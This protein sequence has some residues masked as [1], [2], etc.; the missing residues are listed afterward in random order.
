AEC[1]GARLDC[2]AR[3]GA[4]R[5]GV[6]CGAELIE[7]RIGGL[8]RLIRRSR[9]MPPPLP[10]RKAAPANRRSPTKVAGVLA[11]FHSTL[12]PVLFTTLAVL[13]VSVCTSLRNSSGVLSATSAP[14]F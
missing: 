1:R 7:V 8:P 9:A 3:Q 2:A 4:I 12:R 6:Q 10:A 13:S 14:C 5:R 11:A